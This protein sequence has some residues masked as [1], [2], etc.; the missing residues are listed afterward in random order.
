MTYVTC[1]RA[2]LCAHA[3]AGCEICG[4]GSIGKKCLDC[5]KLICGECV[6]SHR[7]IPS[8]EEHELVDIG[9]VDKESRESLSSLKSE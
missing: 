8:C 5:D 9:T 3:R 4:R 1:M 7:S 2:L 6:A